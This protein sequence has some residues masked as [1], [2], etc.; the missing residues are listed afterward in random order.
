MFDGHS[1]PN[2]PVSPHSAAE[3]AE[4]IRE[5]HLYTEM[6]VGMCAWVLGMHFQ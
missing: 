6:C 4:G 5:S 2:L 3:T 1:R